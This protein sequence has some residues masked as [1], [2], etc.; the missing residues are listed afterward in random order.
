VFDELAAIVVVRAD[1]D[2][3]LALLAQPLGLGRI[4]GVGFG[5]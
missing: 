2:N 3:L 5:T 4:A 1:A